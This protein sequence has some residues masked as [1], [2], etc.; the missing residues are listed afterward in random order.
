MRLIKLSTSKADGSLRLPLNL[1]E[2]GGSRPVALHRGIYK[3][4][5]LAEQS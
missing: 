2:V 3:T 5:P 4:G 1:M